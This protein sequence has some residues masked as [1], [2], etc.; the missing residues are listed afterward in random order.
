MVA[1][2]HG[3]SS[4]CTASHVESGVMLPFCRCGS[5]HGSSVGA[6]STAS[7]GAALCSAGSCGRSAP[8]WLPRLSSSAAR[9]ELSCTGGTASWSTSS[10]CAAGTRADW[11]LA[12]SAP[13]LSD[14]EV[15]TG[16]AACDEGGCSPA[17]WWTQAV[18]ESAAPPWLVSGSTHPDGPSLSETA[19]TS[20]SE[21]AFS[22]SRFLFFFSLLFS[23]L[24][25]TAT[26]GSRSPACSAALEVSVSS[27]GLSSSPGF[28][29]IDTLCSLT[30]ASPPLPTCGSTM[31]GAAKT[32]STA[33]A[34]D[35]LTA[36]LAAGLAETLKTVWTSG[37]SGAP[38]TVAGASVSGAG[39]G[40][41]IAAVSGR[42]SCLMG[43]QKLHLAYMLKV[44]WPGGL[45]WRTNF[46]AR[47]VFPQKR[48][49][50]P[51]E[52]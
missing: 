46:L 26:G 9:G 3:P 27:A 51:L 47:C 24:D 41:L 10:G 34:S 32:V 4:I 14:P 28:A 18:G 44:E 33:D 17:A 7:L 42:W 21:D 19:S 50:T 1:R 11:S 16:S 39:G 8:R 38:E 35:S 49:S 6:R 29:A 36:V 52:K 45:V 2:P 30:A 43:T 22:F 5:M 25:S 31:S 48:M 40:F 23:A 20:A 12:A 13:Q 15:S 37:S